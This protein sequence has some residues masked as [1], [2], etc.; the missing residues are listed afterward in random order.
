MARYIVHVSDWAA[1]ATLSTRPATLGAPFAN[2]FS[3]ADGTRYRS[4]GVPYMYLTDWEMSVKDLRVNN[5]A[6]LTMSLAQGDY[7]SQHD[8][9]PESPL[10]AHVILS[11]TVRQMDSSETDYAFARDA[12]FTRH[13]EMAS[14]PVSH[15]WFVA[16]LEIKDIIVLDYFGG[17]ITVSREDYFAA[18]PFTIDEGRADNRV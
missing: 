5:S 10:C 15:E 18:S 17:A 8:Y 14:W 7:C 4:T 6:S 12:L 1:M 13:P 11:G 2:V 9:D 3:V 16:M